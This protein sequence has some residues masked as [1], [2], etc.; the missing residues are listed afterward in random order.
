MGTRKSLKKMRR[1]GW[2]KVADK[3]HHAMALN[4]LKS[5]Q[6]VSF[7]EFGTQS[8]VVEYLFQLSFNTPNTME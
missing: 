3:Q 7:F 8:P 4:N 2:N 1:I 5:Q 6:Q